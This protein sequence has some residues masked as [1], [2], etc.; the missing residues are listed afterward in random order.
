[1]KK[2]LLS[3]LCAML[4]GASAF[5]GARVHA[6]KP[7]APKAPRTTVLSTL[8]TPKA[9]VVTPKAVE[10]V[11]YAT[12]ADWQSVGQGKWSDCFIYQAVG[13]SAYWPEPCLV[14]IEESQANPGI[15]RLVDPYKYHS[16]APSDYAADRHYYMIVDARD[17]SSVTIPEF[18]TG[19]SVK[20]DMI[21]GRSGAGGTMSDDFIITFPEW[22]LHF[23]AGATGG[24]QSANWQQCFNLRLPQGEFYDLGLD[25]F[26]NCTSNA[27]FDINV[28]TDRDIKSVKYLWTGRYDYPEAANVLA[29]GQELDLTTKVIKADLSNG[30]NYLYLVACDA[31]GNAKAEATSTYYYVND[32]AEGWA[33]VENKILFDEKIASSWFSGDYTNSNAEITIQESTTTKGYFRI[34]NPMATNRMYNNY[35][36]DKNHNHYIY[37]HAEDPDHVWV[38]CSPLGMDFGYGT[39]VIDSYAN[40]MMESKGLTLDEVKANAEV[41]WGTY[42]DDV[43][44]FPAGAI[45]VGMADYY[46]GEPADGVENALRIRFA[47]SHTVTANNAN[48][49]YGSVAIT[50]PETEGTTYTGLA[51]TVEVTATPNEGCAFMYWTDAEGNKVSTNTTYKTVGFED[52]NVTA[53]FG[54]AVTFT[55]PE[56]GLIEVTYEGSEISSGT[57]VV[58]NAEIG[59]RLVPA[60]NYQ[61]ASFTV[62]GVETPLT[63]NRAT[64]IVTEP[65]VIAATFTEA[66]PVIT[67][68]VIGNGKAEIWTDAD[69]NN[70]PAGTQVLSG[71]DVERGTLLYIFMTPGTEEGGN[72]TESITAATVTSASINLNIL[73]DAELIGD[74]PAMIN[75]FDVNED[76]KVAVTFTSNF[77]AIFDIINDGSNAPQRIYN[78]QGV[79][80]NVNNIVP[81]IYIV[82]QGNKV[83]KVYIK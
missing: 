76:T 45:L 49:E 38:E 44:T 17:A 30:K 78:L 34:V 67:I 19:I 5:A 62:N 59:V 47:K 43:I 52:V 54:I 21:W 58:V 16:L 9:A 2:L 12:I 80:V 81:G 39:F 48:P 63:D 14:D 79:E 15:Y 35:Y 74:G 13:G 31:E 65:T 32:T 18:E 50:T 23:R 61:V 37:I 69:T 26:N 29:D 41:L 33:D 40:Y 56:N 20:G 82:R 83:S 8:S 24:W 36:S 55:Q 77:A 73:N 68:E 72:G 28:S 71:N 66:R 6:P 57:P 22:Q 10:A 60:E 51:S 75:Y 25:F 53:H 70:Q 7:D 11:D 64:V 1:M 42:K 4:A 46:D 3:A 27:Q